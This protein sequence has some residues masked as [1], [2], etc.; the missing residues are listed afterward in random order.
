M[1]FSPFFETAKLVPHTKAGNVAGFRFLRSD[2]AR[3]CRETVV[4]LG[5]TESA[6]VRS[7]ERDSLLMDHVE[8]L[9]RVPVVRFLSFCWMDKYR[10]W[11]ETPTIIWELP[12]VRSSGV[13]G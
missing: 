5:K 11:T 10:R 8:G 3:L 1:P 2:Q 13:E 12:A 9:P 6:L 7:L 4:R